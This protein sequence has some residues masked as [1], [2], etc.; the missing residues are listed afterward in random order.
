MP[1]NLHSSDRRL[2][3]IFAWVMIM[4]PLRCSAL[5]PLVST[6]SC[7]STSIL[8]ANLH[9]PCSPTMSTSELSLTEDEQTLHHH[10]AILKKELGAYHASADRDETTWRDV[11]RAHLVFLY[12]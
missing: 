10:A 4:D 5:L 9:Y 1:I 3:N 8:E 2:D 11:F 12:S 6:L 7:L